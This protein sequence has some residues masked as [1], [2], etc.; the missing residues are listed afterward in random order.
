VSQEAPD[1][2]ALE[3]QW[4]ALQARRLE[5]LA[6]Q[7]EAAEQP[8]EA[9]GRFTTEAALWLHNSPTSSSLANIT[10]AMAKVSSHLANITA[11]ITKAGTYLQGLTVSVPAWATV[12]IHRPTKA[13]HLYTRASTSST[14]HLQAACTRSMVRRSPSAKRRRH[15]ERPAEQLARA[16]AARR[17]EEPSQPNATVAM[18]RPCHGLVACNHLITGVMLQT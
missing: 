8:A 2:F 13:A 11:G 10:G 15:T 5:R 17:G 1:T 16:A 6:A 12:V 18:N 3:A 9:V 7:V 4:D 14:E